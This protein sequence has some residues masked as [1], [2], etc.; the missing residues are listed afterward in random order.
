MVYLVRFIGGHHLRDDLG[1]S[2]GL[3]AI[4]VLADVMMRSFMGKEMKLNCK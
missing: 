2:L 4:L 3:G 1:R